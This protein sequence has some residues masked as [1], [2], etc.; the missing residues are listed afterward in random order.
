MSESELPN[1]REWEGKEVRAAGGEK[2]GSL[3]EV[4]FDSEND[5]PAF[6]L[7]KSG[8]FGRRLRLVPAQGVKPGQNYLQISRVNDEVKQAPT[9]TS[10]EQISL[11]DEARVYQYYGLEYLPAPSGRRLVRR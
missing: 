2:L 4:Y 1:L 8:L 9:V 10:G 7:V 11:D 3:E 6:L 5:E